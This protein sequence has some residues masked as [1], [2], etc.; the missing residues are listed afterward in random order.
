MAGPLAT[1]L[2]VTGPTCIG[3]RCRWRARRHRPGRRRCPGSTRPG[4]GRCPCPNACRTVA[5]GPP[6]ASGNPGRTGPRRRPRRTAYRRPSS[7]PAPCR[8]TCAP[9]SGRRRPRGRTCRPPSTARCSR[10]CATSG[11]V[12]RP[13]AARTGPPTAVRGR[14]RPVRACH[15]GKVRTSRRSPGRTCPSRDARPRTA[16]TADPPPCRPSHSARHRRPHHGTA[17]ARGRV[18][19]VPETR[20][21][22][23][24]ASPTRV[25]PTPAPKACDLGIHALRILAR[26]TL[27]LEI[28]ALRTSGLGT[29]ARCTRALQNP[30]RWTAFRIRARGTRGFPTR[31]PRN[32]ARWTRAWPAH[33]RVQQ[34]PGPGVPGPRTRALRGL[35]PETRVRWIPV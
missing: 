34:T 3:L 7:R 27:A 1:G 25:P 32:R 20:V 4:T 14:C 13:R 30:G 21:R 35:I 12:P 15:A 10:P 18:T 26:R 2:P 19:R 22:G 29:L 24:R 31:G 11:P 28:L 6:R 5:D 23:I 9:S 16:G 17:K 33:D 8:R